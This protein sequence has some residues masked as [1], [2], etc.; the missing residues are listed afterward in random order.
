MNPHDIYDFSILG[1]IL[2]NKPMEMGLN[3]CPKFGVFPLNVQI[4]HGEKPLI[5]HPWPAQESS[6]VVP[7]NS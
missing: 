7:G 2:V 3:L 1:D 4:F 5:F 6:P